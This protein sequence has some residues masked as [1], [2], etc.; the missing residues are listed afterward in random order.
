MITIDG[1]SYNIPVLSVRRKADFLDKSAYRT[2][3]GVLHRELIGV[4]FNYEITFGRADPNVHQAVWNKL[5]EP[6]EFHTVTVPDSS[7]DFTFTA[8]FSSVSDELL[9]AKA[10]QNYWHRLQAHF[11]AQAPART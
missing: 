9:K 2:Q 10:E 8:Y 5:S 11:I 4:F 3:D 7:G 1:T 6:E